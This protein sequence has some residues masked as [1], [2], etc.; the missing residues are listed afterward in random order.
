MFFALEGELIKVELNRAVIKLDCIYYEL[1][2]RKKFYEKFKNH[3]NKKIFIYVY[4]YKKED[5]EEIYGF[6]EEDER[7]FFIS[8]INISGIGP[9]KAIE[10]IDANEIESYKEAIINGNI[11]VFEKVKG[12]GKKAAQKI[13]IEL[14]GKIDFK[15]KSK[16]Y[17]E[18]DILNGLKG[19]GFSEESIKNVFNRFKKEIDELETIEEKFKYILS[20]LSKF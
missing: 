16:D 7:D 14:A 6:L 13:M 12:I 11:E 2:T 10:I 8:L 17:S 4:L 3:L 18:L 19:L 5:K 20:K 1:I 15:L 9:K